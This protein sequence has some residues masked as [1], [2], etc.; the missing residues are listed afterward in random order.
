MCEIS[1]LF[2]FFPPKTGAIELQTD[3]V[4]YVAAKNPNLLVDEKKLPFV[5][6]SQENE[7]RLDGFRQARRAIKPGQLIARTREFKPK[8]LGHGPGQQCDVS[9]RIYQHRHVGL[10]LSRIR[11]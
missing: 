8:R 2:L 6:F 7:L 11:I 10:S 1:S 3:V 5:S 9:T 4:Q